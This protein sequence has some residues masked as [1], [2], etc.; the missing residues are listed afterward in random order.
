MYDCTSSETTVNQARKELFTLKGRAIE[1]LPPTQAALIEH[2]KRAA[3]QAG[4]C[5]AHVIVAVPELPSLEDWGRKRKEAGGWE[6]NW[7]TLPEAAKACCE[8]LRCRCKKGCIGQCK[9]IKA[10]L[11]CTALRHCGGLCPRT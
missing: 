4:H 3:Y 8:L 2:T 7:T 11:Q 9:C 6:V 10:A 5:W 1:R